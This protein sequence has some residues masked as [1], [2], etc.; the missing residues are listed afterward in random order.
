MGSSTACARVTA[1][2]RSE[3]LL[4]PVCWQWCWWYWSPGQWRGSFWDFG[5]RWSWD[6]GCDAFPL[7]QLSPTSWFFK[8]STF[9]SPPDE[10]PLIFP[11]NLVKN[12][13]SDDLL[14]L[15]S[16]ESPKVW[17]KNY[18][19]WGRLIPFF[20]QSNLFR[21]FRCLFEYA[22]IWQGSHFDI[23]HSLCSRISPQRRATWDP[24]PLLFAFIP[25]ADFLHLFWKMF[26]LWIPPRTQNSTSTKT[27]EFQT[28]PNGIFHYSLADRRQRFHNA[29]LFQALK[30]DMEILETN[31]TVVLF[32]RHISLSHR[33]LLTDVV[34]ARISLQGSATTAQRDASGLVTFVACLLAFK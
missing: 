15:E 2:R 1:T 4:R 27:G 9:F 20:W 31:Q 18:I 22:Q 29:A 30:H 8:G 24:L 19:L 28:E 6:C 34:R 17:T 25:F 7:F 10:F 3:C 23:L 11:T 13:F 21:I 14:F 16:C 26:S 32:D 33:S 12:H 5:R